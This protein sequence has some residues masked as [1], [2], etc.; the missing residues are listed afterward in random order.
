MSVLSPLSTLLRS[1]F[2]PVFPLIYHSISD[3]IPE[4]SRSLINRLYQLWLVL[5]ATLIVNMVA[6]IFF[7]VAGSSDGGKDLGGSI[8][9]VVLFPLFTIH[10]PAVFKV[11]LSSSHPSP[12]S[13]G[14]GVAF[15]SFPACP[16]LTSLPQTN[17]QRLHEG[18]SSFHLRNR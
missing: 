3:E 5:F 10:N 2:A 16:M 9:H 1:I 15:R 12:S 14:I 11:I 6:C 7:L 4:A 17:I 13:C 8:G 18:S